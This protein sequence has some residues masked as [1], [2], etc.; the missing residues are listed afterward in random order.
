MVSYRRLAGLILIM[1]FLW[2]CGKK[3]GAEDV[4][5]I[6]SRLRYLT[7]KLA[8]EQTQIDRIRTILTE[9]NKELVQL[10]NT[11]VDN[12]R[13][14]WRG[15]RARQE[16]TDTLIASVLTGDQKTH[17]QQLLTL[18]INDNNFIE[19]QAKLNLTVA[20][21]DSIAKILHLAISST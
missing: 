13:E 4:D 5:Y 18:G 16:K 21:S 19:L 2:S 3:E 8:L 10:R 12:P 20:Q 6:G 9:D 1:V 7:A 14:I 15:L 17:Y 11:N